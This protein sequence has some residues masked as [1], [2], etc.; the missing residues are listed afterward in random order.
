[1]PAS[2]VGY[3]I[4]D[5]I[6]VGVGHNQ[7]AA[8]A[9]VDLRSDLVGDR[10]DDQPRHLPQTNVVKLQT[11]LDIVA[12][13]EAEQRRALADP[14]EIPEY[15]VGLTNVAKAG[16]KCPV[17]QERLEDR[18]VALVTVPGWRQ[19]YTPVVALVCEV[20]P[21]KPVTAVVAVRVERLGTQYVVPG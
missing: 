13:C 15:G 7:H 14:Q 1:M 8:I 4:A 16:V 5:G 2:V 19:A 12:G 17:G 3:D 18:P 10:V 20:D 11:L 21:V 9:R 6:L